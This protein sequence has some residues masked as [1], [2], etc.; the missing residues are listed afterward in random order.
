[1]LTLSRPDLLRNS[2][3]ITALRMVVRLARDNG[4]PMI[5]VAVRAPKSTALR[6]RGDL[7]ICG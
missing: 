5:L 2:E 3:K 6:S 4:A 1:V 7:M